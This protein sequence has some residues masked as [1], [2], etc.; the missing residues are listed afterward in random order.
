MIKY[1]TNKD[2][3]VKLFISFTMSF[4][5]GAVIS[6]S[7]HQYTYNYNCDVSVTYLNGEVDT[8]F[9]KEVNYRLFELNNG[10]FSLDGRKTLMSGVR[11]FKILS[12]VKKSE[13][14]KDNG[15]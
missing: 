4:I 9:L 12:T 2:N 15:R 1:L 11:S 3:L 6:K 8:L 10:D 7:I 13:N 5:L 14:A